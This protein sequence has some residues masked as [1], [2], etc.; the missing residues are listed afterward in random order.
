MLALRR[1]RA[2]ERAIKQQA[3]VRH[4]KHDGPKQFL[5]DGCAAAQPKM[6]DERQTQSPPD[7][8]KRIVH[9]VTLPQERA[10]AAAETSLAMVSPANGRRLSG[11]RRVQPDHDEPCGGRSA[12]TA[13]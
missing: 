3:K 4:E 10:G 5:R 11:R 12:P 9:E 7:P 2:E 6:N 1:Q 13:G 8:K